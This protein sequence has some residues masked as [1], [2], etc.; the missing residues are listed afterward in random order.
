MLEIDRPPQGIPVQLLQLIVLRKIRFPENPDRLSFEK[1]LREKRPTDVADRFEVSNSAVAPLLLCL[2]F[3]VDDLSRVILSGRSR[4]YSPLPPFRACASEALAHVAFPRRRFERFPTTERRFV[5]SLR[6]GSTLR[7][8]RGRLVVARKSVD[9]TRV[10]RGPGFH[11]ALAP[12]TA[13]R[14]RKVNT[15]RDRFESISCNPD[16]F[17]WFFFCFFSSLFFFP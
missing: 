4:R 3:L 8:G 17:S 9:D 11:V 15:S 13:N 16:P 5:L 10:P 2:W 1:E 12:A 14:E 6:A 7:I